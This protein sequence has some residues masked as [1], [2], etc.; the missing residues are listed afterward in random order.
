MSPTHSLFPKES[1]KAILRSGA[2]QSTPGVIKAD[3]VGATG[4]TGQELVELLLNHSYVR[5]NNVYSTTENPQKLSS[6]F[7]RF[8]GRTGL[9]V[10][11]L[12]KKKICGGDAAVVFL[13]LPHTCSMEYIPDLLKAGKRVIDLGADYRLK[14]VAVY[15]KAYGVAHQDKENLSNSVYGLPELYRQ[16]LRSAYLVANP[17]CYA[18]ACLLGLAPLVSLQRVTSIIVDAK[19]GTSGAGKKAVQEMLFT[20]VNEDFRAYKV[21]SHQH[22]PEVEQELSKLAGKRTRITFVPHLLPLKRGILATM[23]VSAAVK[24]SRV[25][26]LYKK[27]Y[28]NEPFVRVRD[29]GIFPAIKDVAGTNFCDI[30]LKA[31][32]NNSIVICAIDNL[33]KGASGQA[34][35]NMNILFGFPETMGLE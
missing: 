30:G 6:L 18:T 9:E 29:E 31:D 14:N 25:F 26:E 32:G 22:I 20:E 7:P 10:H 11:K 16:K 12:D 13:A 27:F 33:L 17:G 35:Q 3:I 34:V 5:I 8:A 23:Y 21:N 4:Y 28:K 1:R 19:S 2:C 15:Q 24:P